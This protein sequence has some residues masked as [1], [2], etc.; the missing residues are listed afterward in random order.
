MPLVPYNEEHTLQT[1]ATPILETG[2]DPGFFDVLGPAFRQENDVF[3]VV[4]MLS[5]PVFDA[6][7][8]FDVQ[9]A[10]DES[11][12]RLDYFEELARAQSQAEFDDI[13]ARLTREANERRQLAAAG[14]AG[15]AAS[16]VAGVASP[17]MFIPLMGPSR[18]V[19][20]VAEA[21]A[22]G[23]AAATSQEAVLYFA[24]ERRTKEEALLGITA[25]TILGGALG[26]AGVYLRGQA[27][28]RIE[29][30]MAHGQGA[31]T[32]SYAAGT[33]A[34]EAVQATPTSPTRDLSAPLADYD[35]KAPQVGE[36]VVVFDSKGQ[37]KAAVVTREGEVMLDSGEVVTLGGA[38]TPYNPRSPE[39]KLQSLGSKAAVADIQD[40][41]L[42]QAVAQLEEQLV[43]IPEDVKTPEVTAAQQD[44]TALVTEA[45]RRMKKESVSRGAAKID[46]PI[47]VTDP[48][49]P[50]SPKAQVDARM[51]AAAQQADKL[52]D[53]A[54]PTHGDLPGTPKS[55][56]AA[57][58]DGPQFQRFYRADPVTGWINDQL[59]K[60][61]PVNRGIEN[62]DSP[63]ASW[64]SA[65]MA[66]AGMLMEGNQQGIAHAVGGP[67]SDRANAHQVAL[68]K[69]IQAFDNAY[70]NHVHGTAH[71]IEDTEGVMKAKIMSGLGRLPEG[72]LTEKEFGDTTFRFLSLGE[73]HPDSAVMSGVNAQRS[74]YDYFRDVAEEAYQERVRLEGPQARRLFDPNGNLGPD[75]QEYAHDIYNT[76]EI[77][78]NPTAFMADIK[79]LTVGQQQSSFT[80]AV[81]KFVEKEAK[82]QATLDILRM[83]KKSRKALR[84]QVNKQVTD[85]E[86]EPE[87]KAY[88]D[89]RKRLMDERTAARAA[90]KEAKQELDVTKLT[91]E[92]ADAALARQADD[93]EAATADFDASE[94]AVKS[95]EDNASQQVLATQGELVTVRRYGKLLDDT[96]DS[97]AKRATSQETKMEK[98][99][100]KFSEHWRK[101]GA[102][103]VSIT[104]RSADFTEH[105]EEMATLLFNKI[106]G[107]KSRVSGMDI[108]QGDRGPQ[109]ART[110][111]LPFEQKV[112]WLHTEPEHIIRRY[113]RQMS[114][115]VEIYRA[116]G[117]SNASKVFLGIEEDFDKL[118]F[119]VDN[120]THVK[121]VEGILRPVAA[122]T[123]GAK[124][125]TDKLRKDMLERLRKSQNNV[126]SDMQVLIDRQRHLRG[127]P[128]NP[129]GWLFRG[130][131]MAM[132]MNVTRLMGTV[133]LSSMSELARPVMKRGLLKTFRDGYGPMVSDLTRLKMTRE[134]A[135][136]L[137]IAWDPILHNRL[138]AVFD[139][140]EDNGLPRTGAEK[141]TGFLANKTGAV[142]LFDRWTAE[143]K[144]IA[145]SVGM[146][147]T[148]RALRMVVEGG[149]KAKALKDARAF[150]AQ[151]GV[152]EPLARKI[153]DQFMK[154]GGSTEFDD[155][156][157]LPNLEA[158]GDDYK[159]MSAYRALVGKFTDDTIIMPGLD[160]PSWVDAN[161]GARM[162]AQFRSF[163]FTSTNRVVMAGLQ[164]RDM[165][166]ISG[167]SISLAMGA[168][169]YYLWATSVGGKAE[170]EMLSGDLDKWADESIARSG[171]TGVFAEAQRVAERIPGLEQYATF[172]GT[173]VRN[174]QPTSLIGSI[175]GPSYDLAERMSR[176]IMGLDEPTQQTLHQ[177]RLMSA[178][179]NV[180]WLRQGF[181]AVEDVAVDVLDLP[182]RRGN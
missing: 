8:D 56:G 138:Q 170:K 152:D 74:L 132:D 85:L 40:A 109:L 179:Q 93:L 18:G 182:E 71:A 77:A 23:A 130:G 126:Q 159:T 30:D 9:A 137:G 124:P 28:A 102:T 92:E 35:V 174:R 96:P 108:L 166:L 41:K 44:Y 120:A 103:D 42:V 123:A 135:R 70:S 121:K 157:R 94:L 81:T 146:S 149:G 116:F 65:R 172:S 119:Q 34:R 4:D 64:A 111:N 21:F 1:A 97:S 19:K 115:D 169:S 173:P 49:A 105:G 31:E 27:R 32:I 60:L 160:R 113:A 181:D 75:V 147:E 161:V 20:G 178:Y 16:I 167:V 180:F 165:A 143:M 68:G 100:D 150:L 66:D 52:P 6:D 37:G 158:W 91:P 156:V 33:S 48:D 98:A 22:L 163:T 59:T 168:L 162:L 114:S 53:Q 51:Q 142:A 107:L 11:P 73:Q 10:V 45:N 46:E 62:P 129:E 25:G 67:V 61:N 148:S 104:A 17:T 89:E 139:M 145:A 140:M 14:G 151:H 128:D 125:I 164:Q 153:W 38:F 2:E 57:A 84:A 110:L 117:S 141:V 144:L 24:Q 101:E 106:T 76:Q 12:F 134:N 133:V 43:K 177:A 72:K 83:D 79:A 99:R 29:A 127:M 112:K 54:I 63:T 78:Q 155:G 176:V 82:E 136:E 95:Y 86:A 26:S 3:A 87:M 39:Y 15:I 13:S 122:D 69:F 80:K 88:M 7:P 55:V 90:V 36:A 47:G 118:R 5:R 50:V 131:R 171:L 58:V 154:P 175:A